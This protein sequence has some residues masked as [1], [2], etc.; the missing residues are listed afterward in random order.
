M[1]GIQ[2]QRESFETFIVY[3][4]VIDAVNADLGVIGSPEPVRSV[5]VK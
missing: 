5:S 4:V 3:E 1:C 2:F